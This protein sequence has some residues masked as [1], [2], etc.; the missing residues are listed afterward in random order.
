MCSPEILIIII[1]TQTL[2]D[3]YLVNRGQAIVGQGKANKRIVERERE[4]EG[5]RSHDKRNH[6]H[7]ITSLAR[8]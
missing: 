5:E 3:D 2:D 4:R 8:E 6:V 7:F 1:N